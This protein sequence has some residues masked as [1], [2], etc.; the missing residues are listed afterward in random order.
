[1]LFYVYRMFYVLLLHI[2]CFFCTILEF[3]EKCHKT[4]FIARSRIG[5]DT[6]VRLWQY[7][8]KQNEMKQLVMWATF[9]VTGELSFLLL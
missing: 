9:R 2:C 1:M 6:V 3:K 5:T 4:R 7:S 8:D